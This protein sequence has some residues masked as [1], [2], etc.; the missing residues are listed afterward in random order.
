MATNGNMIG[1]AFA[2]VLTALQ[3]MHSGADRSQKSHAHT[4]LEEFQKS[5]GS[6]LMKL[7]GHKTH[8][9]V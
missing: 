4:F 7:G 6:Y 2:P 8:L 3:T 5:V 9:I 1:Q